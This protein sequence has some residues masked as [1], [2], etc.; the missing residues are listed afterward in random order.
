[1]LR[2]VSVFEPHRLDEV[3]GACRTPKATRRLGVCRQR[4]QVATAITIIAGLV[5][6]SAPSFTT[7]GDIPTSCS[8]DKCIRLICDITGGT[9]IARCID[10]ESR[11]QATNRSI[12][13]L[14]PY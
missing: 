13:Y 4:Q 1:M 2:L 9:C 14:Y 6:K 10:F 11:L 5:T 7:T 8:M 12:C 3:S